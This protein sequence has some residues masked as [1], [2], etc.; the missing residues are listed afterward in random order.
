MALDPYKVLGLDRTADADQVKQ[1]YRK[2]AMKHHPDR[3]SGNDEKF[4]EI[5]AAYDQI[6]NGNTQQHH[7]P[8]FGS[9]GFGFDFRNRAD[10]EEFLREQ[11]FRHQMQVSIAMGISIKDAVIG[12]EHIVELP[13]HGNKITAKV[14]IPPGIR[15]GEAIRYPKLIRDIDVVIRYQIL[16]DNV[17]AIDRGVLVKRQEISIWDLITGAE[18]D[19]ELIDDS[20][21]RLRIPERTQANTTMRVRGKGINGAD[22]LLAVIPVIPEDIPEPILKAIREN[23]G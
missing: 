7:H 20:V 22:M 1:A 14:N 11:R 18:L 17:W 23:K 21:I 15:D 16:P 9:A 19:V 13:V 10:I 2:L 8:G 3:N 5:Q 6:K 4:K 12:G